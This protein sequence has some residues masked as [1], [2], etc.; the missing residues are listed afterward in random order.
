MH[1]II[2]E[3]A[4]ELEGL[5]RSLKLSAE[6][7]ATIKKIVQLT[8]DCIQNG[9]RI[10]IFGNGGSAADAQHIAAEFVGR[11]KKERR[12]FSAEALTVNT[13]VLTALSNDYDFSI[14]FSRQVEAYVDSG[15][16]C[17]GL[18]TSGNAENVCKG[19]KIARQLG[20]NTIAITGESGGK[21][22][23]EADV[24]LLLP[25]EDTP[26]IQEMTIFSAHVICEMVEK[27]LVQSE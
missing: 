10:Y 15:D 18:S 8:V 2:K 7:E 1:D 25:S 23:L 17:V 9:K 12:A 16:I 26:R 6:W 24:C 22:S 14:V 11:F 27:K 13:S 19:L 4:E 20:A 21:V 3:R 5:I